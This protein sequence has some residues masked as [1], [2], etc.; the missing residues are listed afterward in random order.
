MILA[1]LKI[2]KL[3]FFFLWQRWHI[4]QTL[5]CE[6]FQLCIQQYKKKKTFPNPRNIVI[7][8]HPKGPSLSCRLCSVQNSLHAREK[9]KAAPAKINIPGLPERVRVVEWHPTGTEQSA[10]WSW[11]WATNVQQCKKWHIS[12]AHFMNAGVGWQQRKKNLN[13][14]V[15]APCSGAGRFLCGWCSLSCWNRQVEKRGGA[16]LLF[17]LVWQW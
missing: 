10:W 1:I 5:D 2:F 16:E 12:R 6:I 3:I 13:N 11:S 4:R 7:F 14:G 8:L 15:S 9:K 17:H